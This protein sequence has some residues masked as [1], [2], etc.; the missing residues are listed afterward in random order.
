M[1]SD[2]ANLL[3]DMLAGDPLIDDAMEFAR[4]IAGSPR[5]PGGLLLVGTP[6]HEPWHLTAHIEDEAR[7]S[8]VAEISPTLVRWSAPADAAPHLAVT[9]ERLERARRGETLLVVAADATPSSLLERVDDARRSGATILS[10]AHDAGELTSLSHDALIVPTGG[11]LLDARVVD[12]LSAVSIAGLD[13]D[14]MF[15]TAQ[16][17]VSL[18]VGEAT[19]NGTGRAAR[20]RGWR[21]IM[22]SLDGSPARW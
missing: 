16:H 12:S 18:G 4:A 2:R 5:T 13:D 7:I 14:P 1:D 17:I 15:D 19:R 8:G 6:T 3:R 9:L 11:A 22:S 21:R 10:M 20:K